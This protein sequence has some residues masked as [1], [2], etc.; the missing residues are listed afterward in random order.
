MDGNKTDIY[1]S[2]HSPMFMYVSKITAEARLLLL[3]LLL[4]VLVVNSSSLEQAMTTAHRCQQWSEMTDNKKEFFIT[5]T[6]SMR[7]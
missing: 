5:N 4:A 2:I 7:K 1:V 3:L 6:T